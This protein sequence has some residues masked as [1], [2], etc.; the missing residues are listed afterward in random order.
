MTRPLISRKQFGTALFFGVA[1]LFFAYAFQELS[2][3]KTSQMFVLLALFLPLQ[4]LI[5]SAAEKLSWRLQ[6]VAV[7]FSTIGLL[8]FLNICYDYL[9]LT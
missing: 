6:I 7:G 8:V 1:A 4:I 9:S 5:L 2:A 3:N